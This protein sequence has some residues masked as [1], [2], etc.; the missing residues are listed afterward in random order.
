M[1]LGYPV[2]SFVDPGIT[3]VGSR[4]NLLGEREAEDELRRDLSA[5]CSLLP[6][7]PPAF[8]FHAKDDKGVPIG[9]SKTYCK[10][11]AAIGRPAELCTIA[12]GGHGFGSLIDEWME[13]CRN[14][15]LRTCLA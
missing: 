1:I 15:L 8:L 7:A 2:I 4:E 12:E 3:H 5:E 14:W 10:A 13:P 9:N 6:D 11:M